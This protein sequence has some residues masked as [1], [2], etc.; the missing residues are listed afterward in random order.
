MSLFDK[1]NSFSKLSGAI[2]RITALVLMTVVLGG[3]TFLNKEIFEIQ[4]AASAKRDE[5]MQGI[6]AYFQEIGF[7]P[8]RKTDYFYPEKRKITSYFLG[9]Y[10]NPVLLYSSY[11]HLVLRLEASDILYIDWIKIS[12]LREK[13]RPGEFDSIHKK[14][15]DDLMTR[16]GVSVKFTPVPDIGTDQSGK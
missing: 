5:V 7:K 14:I 1:L 15:A 12:D 8:E 3:C 16:L 10:E 9:Y 11:S 13:P 4:P 2:S 6:E